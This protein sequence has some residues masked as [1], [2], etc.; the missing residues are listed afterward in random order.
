MQIVTRRRLRPVAFAAAALPLVEHTH[1]SDPN[2]TFL[3][4]C[5]RAPLGPLDPGETRAALCQPV[6]DTG[7]VPPSRIPQTRPNRSP[8][9]PHLPALNLSGR[10]RMWP[11]TSLRPVEPPEAA[12]GYS[13]A[14]M[15]TRPPASTFMYR[16]WPWSNAMP[17][18][19]VVSAA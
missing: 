11:M 14:W 17:T 1:L 9:Q 4:R 6:V 18:S 13:S 15:T 3:Q 7:P 8:R 16:L 5:A 10:L 12:S 2:M 19:G